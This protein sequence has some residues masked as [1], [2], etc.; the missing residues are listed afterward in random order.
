MQNLSQY[1][2]L[3]V[4]LALKSQ[5]ITAWFFKYLLIQEIPYVFSGWVVHIKGYSLNYPN[6]IDADLELTWIRYSE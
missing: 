5:V 2:I 1:V 3:Q 4:I 6:V